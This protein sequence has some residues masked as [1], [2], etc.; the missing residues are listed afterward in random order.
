MDKD[1]FEEKFNK[2]DNKLS[3]VEKRLNQVEDS[4]NLGTLDASILTLMIFI[5]GLGISLVSLG[6]PGIIKNSAPL[7]VGFIYLLVLII[8]VISAIYGYALSIFEKNFRFGRKIITLTILQGLM[9]F[10]VG[11]WMLL[12][13]FWIYESVLKI[14]KISSLAVYILAGAV[15][16]LSFVY[17]W[18]YPKTKEYFNQ[19]FKHIIKRRLE[20]IKR[21]KKNKQ[22]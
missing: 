11:I 21:E 17:C 2:I 1:Y 16:I 19:S 12:F 10:V 20:E 6:I 22:K 3:Y 9:M 13:G 14:G 4:V 5:V 18:I 15:L 7:F 8:P